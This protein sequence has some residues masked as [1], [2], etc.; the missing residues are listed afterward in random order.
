MDG[1][2][3]EYG[4]TGS[5]ESGEGGGYKVS[6]GT[7][8]G[9]RSSEENRWKSDEDESGDEDDDDDDEDED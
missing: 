7:R 5:D 3:V 2:L 9:Q 1:K 6:H 4:N 8:M